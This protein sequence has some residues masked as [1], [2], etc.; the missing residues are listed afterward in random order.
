MKRLFLSID[1]PEFVRDDLIDLRISSHDVK[2][3]MWDNY[4]LTLKFLGDD[5]NRHTEA[6]IIYKL[7]RLSFERFPLALSSVGYFGSEKKPR[8][9]Y[10]GVE[11]NLKLLE[12]Q[13]GLVDSLRNLDI[14]LENKKYVPHVTLGRPLKLSYEKVAEFMQS[15]STYRSDEFLVDKFYLMQ[16]ELT[17]HGAHYSIIHEFELHQQ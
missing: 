6:D 1:L 3:T 4:H 8:V 11:S 5:I 7:E 16:S 2:W 15:F 9:L 10:A 14:E 13:K 17:R 12:L